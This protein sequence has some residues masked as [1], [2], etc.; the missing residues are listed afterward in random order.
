MCYMYAIL[1]TMS[2]NMSPAG[3][4][5]RWP[6]RG[7]KSRCGVVLGAS[8]LLF[9]YMSV[10]LPARESPVVA[11]VGTPPHCGASAIAV[12]VGVAAML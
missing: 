12:A 9:S 5:G 10:S 8:Q 6:G 2:F 11:D 1:T 4:G 7:V 3:A